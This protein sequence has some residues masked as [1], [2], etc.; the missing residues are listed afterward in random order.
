MK[1]STFL[2]CAALI[3]ISL[4]IAHIYK[5]SSFIKLSY[6]KQKVERE[7]E[8]LNKQAQILTHSQITMHNNA[9]VKETALKHGLKPIKISQI[10][11][12]EHD[13]NS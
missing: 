13:T 6:R 12:I 10:K 9:Q 3:N 7:C 5:Q 1:R 11:K 8:A 2:T 4:I